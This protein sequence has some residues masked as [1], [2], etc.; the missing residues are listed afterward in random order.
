MDETRGLLHS[1]V[2]IHAPVT[3]GVTQVMH[4]Q[5]TMV[6]PAQT[7]IFILKV[8]KEVSNLSQV[9][10]KPNRENSTQS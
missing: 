10:L 6:G 4:F 7:D 1:G 3:A 9:H 8:K 5:I 2:D